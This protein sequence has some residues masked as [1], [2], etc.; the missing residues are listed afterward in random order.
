M[1]YNKFARGNVAIA[2]NNFK[3][4]VLWFDHVIPFLFLG[5]MRRAPRANDLSFHFNYP[6][7]QSSTFLTLV[8][9]ENMLD[10]ASFIYD[11]KHLFMDFPKDILNSI[12]RF[13]F[14]VLNKISQYILTL[15]PEKQTSR[16][17]SDF[18]VIELLSLFH[19]PVITIPYEIPFVEKKEDNIESFIITS[20]N[21]AKIDCNNASWSQIVEIKTDKKAY[22][23]LR[24]YRLFWFKN[25]QNKEIAFIH[26]DMCDR[27]EKYKS[28][29]KKHGFNVLNT[30]VETLVKSKSLW[31]I[32]SLSL[33]SKILQIP[34]NIDNILLLGAVV[35]LGHITLEARKVYLENDIF[36]KES[37]IAYLNTVSKKLSGD[38]G[39]SRKEGKYSFGITFPNFFCSGSS[40]PKSDIAEN[41]K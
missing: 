1:S 7:G 24:K 16:F 19:S 15:V 38:T 3:E 41:S 29:S 32:F 35:E 40:L 26:D 20:K 28:A 21:V 39:A 10:D 2:V 17:Y 6:F 5:G 12:E 27:L 4:H 33:I 9:D 23:A 25:Y 14:P 30:S 13:N 36:Q 18:E 8:V 11:H 31:S 22:E 34:F 37:D